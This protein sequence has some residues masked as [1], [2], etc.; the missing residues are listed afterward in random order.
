MGIAGRLDG[1]GTIVPGCGVDAVDV[2]RGSGTDPA[3]V[4]WP[5]RVTEEVG[6]VESCRGGG[7]GAGVDSFAVASISSAGAGEGS[8][9]RAY[10]VPDGATIREMNR[11][12]RVRNVRGLNQRRVLIFSPFSLRSSLDAPA[13]M[14]AVLRVPP[15]LDYRS[16]FIYV[17]LAN[18]TP[19]VSFLVGHQ[20]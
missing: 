4:G 7:A 18:Y 3:G 15:G 12:G 19:K 5:A 14:R 9:T 2:E 17:K 6:L 20:H 10:A 8:F 11:R 13:T 16:S 1:T